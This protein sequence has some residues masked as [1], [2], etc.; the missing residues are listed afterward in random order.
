MLVSVS[1][2]NV[3]CIPF[4]FA[5]HSVHGVLTYVCFLALAQ[6]HKAALFPAMSHHSRMVKKEEKKPEQIPGKS[7]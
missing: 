5:G 3:E 1:T 7:K 4:K 2:Y 6:V